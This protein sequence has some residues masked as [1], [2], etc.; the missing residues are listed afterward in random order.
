MLSK[1]GTWMEPVELEGPRLNEMK[2]SKEF[3][4]LTYRAS[5]ESFVA[6]LKYRLL[7]NDKKPAGIVQQKTA[8][9]NLNASGHPLGMYAGAITG[10]F[11]VALFLAIIS[12]RRSS[13]SLS[14]FARGSGRSFLLHF[15]RGGVATGIAILVLQTTADN[16]FPISVSVED[17]YGGV[18]LGLFGDQ[19]AQTI[20]QRVSQRKGNRQVADGEE[21]GAK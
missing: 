15:A 11:L 19:L 17:F 5:K 18:L 8:R 3:G 16:R 12:R 6:I 7:N 2:L 10:A 4:L 21:E 14:S 1:L 13:S 20:Q 9:L